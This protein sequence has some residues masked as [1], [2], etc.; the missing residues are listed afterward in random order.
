MQGVYYRKS[1]QEI[2]HQLDINGFVM[3]LGDGSVYIEAEGNETALARLVKWCHQG[4][5]H[6]VVNGVEVSELP[7]SGYQGFE[8]RRT[9]Y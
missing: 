6:A 8:V 3:N 2:A 9:S 5:P 7:A 1:T 4:P